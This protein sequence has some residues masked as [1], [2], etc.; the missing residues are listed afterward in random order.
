MLNTSGK[1]KPRQIP[2]T[3]GCQHCAFPILSCASYSLRHAGIYIQSKTTLWHMVWKLPQ[4]YKVIGWE[5]TKLN[6]H[7]TSWKIH[8]TESDHRETSPQKPS[9]QFFAHSYRSIPPSSFKMSS[10][11]SLRSSLNCHP[12]VIQL[13]HD[14][15]GRIPSW[16]AACSQNAHPF[17]CPSL[18]HASCLLAQ[19]CFKQVGEHARAS[20]KREELQSTLFR[21]SRLFGNA[22]ASSRKN[23]AF[24]APGCLPC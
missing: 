15:A 14:R 2:Q 9:L 16:A 19:I 12:M 8:E 23:T 21:S 10:P 17:S 3:S 4:N 11:V 24:M 20:Q 7:D 6:W 13:T 22:S 18:M 1:P 5:N